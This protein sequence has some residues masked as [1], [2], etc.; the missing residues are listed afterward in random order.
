[1]KYSYTL[2]G[3]VKNRGIDIVQP[4]ILKTL[5]KKELIEII[6]EQRDEID[7]LAN[8]A[9]SEWQ[10]AEILFKKLDRIERGKR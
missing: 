5:S 3:I 6:I 10:R 4:K 7:Y 2:T 1:M 9:Q 8:C